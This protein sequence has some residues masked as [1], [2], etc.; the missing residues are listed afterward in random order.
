MY[1]LARRNKISAIHTQRDVNTVY[2]RYS[3]FTTSNKV[4]KTAVYETLFKK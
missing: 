1:W 3:A 4:L 2:R